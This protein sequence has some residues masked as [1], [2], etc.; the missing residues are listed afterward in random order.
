MGYLPCRLLLLFS[1]DPQI[2]VEDR[3]IGY[4]LE[5][6]LMMVAIQQ[7]TEKHDLKGTLK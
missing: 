7:R 3:E 2:E 5:A 6:L 1:L 4:H